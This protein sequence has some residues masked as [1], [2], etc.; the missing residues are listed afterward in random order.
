M[1]FGAASLGLVTEIEG[2]ECAFG[3]SCLPTPDWRLPV[4]KRCQRSGASVTRVRGFRKKNCITK[5]R[6]VRV[7]AVHTFRCPTSSVE[8][9]AGDDGSPGSSR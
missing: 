3:R 9:A 2:S 1:F 7:I 5:I 8:I 6:I 4:G